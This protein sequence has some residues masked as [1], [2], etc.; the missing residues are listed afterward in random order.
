MLSPTL[1]SIVLLFVLSLLVHSS[2]LSFCSLLPLFLFCTRANGF[3]NLIDLCTGPS[4]LQSRATTYGSADG[5]S[6]STRW[7]HPNDCSEAHQPWGSWQGAISPPSATQAH[8]PPWAVAAYFVQQRMQCQKG[9]CAQC[10][11]RPFC[12]N[13]CGQCRQGTSFM[14]AGTWT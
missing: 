13:Q 2:F 14:A 9:C 5:A 7:V 3:A 6:A 1:L 4:L 12:G 11:T 10:A 8:F